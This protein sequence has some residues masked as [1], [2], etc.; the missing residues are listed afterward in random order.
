MAERSEAFAGSRCTGVKNG[1]LRVGRI[2][3]G[4]NHRSNSSVVA[5][6]L[7]ILSFVFGDRT[8]STAGSSLVTNRWFHSPSQ[9]EDLTRGDEAMALVSGALLR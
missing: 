1:V 6:L 2:L 8:R 4:T 9:R 5:S 7:E 3:F